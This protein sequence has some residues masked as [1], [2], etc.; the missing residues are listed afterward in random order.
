MAEQSLTYGALNSASSLQAGCVEH[1]DAAI[2]TTCGTDVCLSGELYSH[3][4]VNASSTPG[5]KAIEDRRGSSCVGLVAHADA[6]VD[7]DDCSVDVGG[8]VGGEPDDGGG[9]F[10][11]LGEAPEGDHLAHGVEEFFGYLGGHVRFG[12]AGGCGL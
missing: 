12:E 1:T 3:L 6:A 2:F 10:F 11:G 5:G 4:S 7:G 8:G 9:D